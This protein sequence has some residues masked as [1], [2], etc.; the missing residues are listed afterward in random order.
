MVEG[1]ETLGGNFLPS[2][3]TTPS[4]NGIAVARTC[5]V[6]GNKGSDDK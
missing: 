4:S 1:K 3:K 6:G 2:P 5:I